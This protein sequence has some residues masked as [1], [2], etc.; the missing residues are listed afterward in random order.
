MDIVVDNNVLSKSDDFYDDTYKETTCFN[1]CFPKGNNNLREI[2][3]KWDVFIN[4]SINIGQSHF[5]I[6][7]NL[8]DIIPSN[9]TTS[10]R[11]EYTNVLKMHPFEVLKKNKYED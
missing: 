4:D 8:P 3:N 11:Q 10:I 9:C 5:A 2:F 7:I 1:Y 6:T